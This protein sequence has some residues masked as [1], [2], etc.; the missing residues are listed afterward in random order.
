[1]PEWNGMKDNL[2]YFHSNSILDFV[3]CIHT[4]TFSNV[5]WL[6]NNIV[7][8]VYHFSI[9][10]YYLS[11]NRGTLVVF[12]AQTVYALHHSN[13]IAICS[14]GVMVDDFD[15]FDLFCFFI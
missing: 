13:Y 6:K 1:M 5:G 7:A 15:R 10:A 11:T 9:Y 12:I 3:H 14:I 4:K 2:P 8:E